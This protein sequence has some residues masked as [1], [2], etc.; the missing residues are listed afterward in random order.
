MGWFEN[1][2]NIWGEGGFK[3]NHLMYI[4]SFMIPRLVTI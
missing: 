1:N 4:M 2:I 3:L